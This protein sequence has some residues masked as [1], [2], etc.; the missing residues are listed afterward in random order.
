MAN[1]SD[2]ADAIGQ[3]IE[4]AIEK[5][6]ESATESAID[7]KLRHFDPDD[8]VQE[9]D[10]DSKFNDCFTDSII[11]VLHDAGSGNLCRRGQQA[12]E[13]F[14]EHLAQEIDLKPTLEQ[15]L[16]QLRQEQ[17]A[18]EANRW[19]RRLARWLKSRARLSRLVR[20]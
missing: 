17:Q 15:A 5:T 9:S 2:I 18:A 16:A 13:A 3:A 7:D 4:Q 12:L 19:H 8:F 1:L 20:A 14:V 6:V 10:F 11:E